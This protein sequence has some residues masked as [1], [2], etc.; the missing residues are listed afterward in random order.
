MLF[1]EIKSDFSILGSMN[2]TD[3]MDQRR[4][5]LSNDTVTALGTAIN[6]NQENSM[7]RQ[8]K[9]DGG[10]ISLDDPVRRFMETVPNAERASI[11]DPPELFLPGLIIHI[12]PEKTNFPPIPIWKPWKLQDNSD[13]FKVY[14]ANKDS[15][16]DLVVSPS[17]FLDHLPWRYVAF[18]PFESVFQ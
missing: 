8:L 3:A 1:L 2:A 14:V 9:S 18:I 16:K 11:F 13:A 10:I 4:D 17:M 6:N 7:T 15:F 12:V 5:L